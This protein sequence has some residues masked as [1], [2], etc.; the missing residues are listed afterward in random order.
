[1]R[2]RRYVHLTSNLDIRK[3]GSYFENV[4]L[5]L[6]FKLKSNTKEHEHTIISQNIGRNK[7]NS[8]KGEKSKVLCEDRQAKGQVKAQFVKQQQLGHVTDNYGRS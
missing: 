5:S 6:H 8:L 7:L 1:M 3:S 2:E 4:Q